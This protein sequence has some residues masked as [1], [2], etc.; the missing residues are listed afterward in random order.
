MRPQMVQAAD[1]ERER[2]GSGVQVAP[3]AA[4]ITAFGHEL[5]ASAGDTNV[6]V[7][8]ASIAY[9]F[10]MAR[11]GAGGET[12]AQIDRVLGFPSEGLHEALNAITYETVTVDA[13][14]PT[15]ASGEKRKPGEPPK[16]P[17][18]TVANGLFARAGFSFRQEF[19]RT[20]AAYYGSGVQTVDFASQ[21]AADL[22]NAWAAE[23]TAG[24]IKQ[25][26]ERLDPET[27]MVL[28]NAVYF[29][30]D[31]RVPFEEHATKDAAFTT[32][33]GEQKTAK[34]MHQLTRLDYAIGDRWKA[35]ELPYAGDELAMR[36]IVPTGDV[37]PAAL[38]TSETL[39]SVE[40]SLQTG[41]V[42]FSM[43]R[44]D[45]ETDIRLTNSLRELG[46]TAPFDPDSAD[47]S[48]ISA[49]E[50]LY[51]SQAVHKANITVDE[52]GT[53]AAAV[54]AVGMQ[55]T[56]VPVA[57]ATIRA[58]RAFAFTIVHKPTGTPLFMGQVAD[59]TA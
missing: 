33:S 13:P 20:L 17:V 9:A 14:P 56:S 57:E 2:P 40:D 41:M 39:R 21:D 28:A 48:G 42:S 59:P 38:L 53:E 24:R 49:E 36:V 11:A 51:I 30:G 12:A 35:V 19:L 8:P 29:K 7:S 16:P 22:I 47:F 44:F 54:T 10:G 50:R 25:V 27:A 37:S 6:V 5:L 52:W 18:V 32:A 55:V 4:G 23:Q 34:M 15:P 45:F 58:D 43:P 31:W 26:F 3:T 46:M 1:I